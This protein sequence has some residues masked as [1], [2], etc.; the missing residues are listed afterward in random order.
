MQSKRQLVIFFFVF[1]VTGCATNPPLE[2]ILA[3]DRDGNAEY[4]GRTV[5]F[6]HTLKDDKECYFEKESEKC[7][8]DRL[9]KTDNNKILIYIHGGL[10]YPLQAT[11]KAKELIDL[12][13]VTDNVYK[14]LFIHW[15][16]AL[17]TTY[18]EHLFHDR[19]GEHW[20]TAGL[21]TAPFVLLEDLG[22]GLIRSPMTMLRT[23]S[24]YYKSVVFDK[25]P[26]EFSAFSM[27]KHVRTDRNSVNSLVSNFGELPL[28]IDKRNKV[29]K[30]SDGLLNFAYMG[31]SLTTVPIFDALG[32]GAW[33]TMKRRTEIMFTKA[34]PSRK[35]HS[36]GNYRE[37]R[38]GVATRLID[39]LARKQEK[40]KT[41][42][43]LVAHSMGTII[44]N[45]ILSNWP[46]LEFEKI[47]Y[48][49]AASSIE[50]YRLS[51]LPYLRRHNHTVFYNYSLHPIAE[52]TDSYG[53]GLGGFGSLLTQID[54]FY[55]APITEDQRTLGRW[56]NVMNGI[57][58]LIGKDDVENKV[59]ERLCFRTLPLGS[60]YPSKHGDFDE[61][62]FITKGKFWEGELGKKDG[63]K[64]KS[65]CSGELAG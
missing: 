30:V 17:F 36:N 34:R 47:I 49:A 39:G 60:E 57:I 26:G 38:E 25:S 45:K 29:E 52:N 32:T 43:I 23:V 5:A 46:E 8:I 22:R 55:E 13:E 28:L 41:K 63:Y 20:K 24:N 21:L 40:D 33:A 64:L 35:H 1:A 53:F 61:I 59:A 37:Q 12:I 51:V 9:L 16:S 42:I 54:N 58:Y 62:K 50:D 56:A 19:Q 6:D 2:N 31:L 48:M 3:I 7:Y 4:P 27:D 18:K 65:K 14:P 15:R 44:A 10:N 11:T